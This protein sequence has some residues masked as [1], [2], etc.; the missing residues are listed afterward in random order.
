MDDEA[1]YKEVA[2]DAEHLIVEFIH[3]HGPSSIPVVL[4]TA[5][6]IAVKLGAADLVKGTLTRL[7]TVADDMAAEHRKSGY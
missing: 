3:A 7:V 6:M 2:D 1:E 5:V 4:A